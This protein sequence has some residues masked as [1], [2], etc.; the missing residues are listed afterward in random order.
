MCLVVGGG[1]GGCL[2]K[3]QTMFSFLLRLSVMLFFFVPFV[4]LLPVVVERLCS[5]TGRPVVSSFVLLMTASLLASRLRTK[6][7]NGREEA[8]SR[9]KKVR[10]SCLARV[11]LCV[12]LLVRCGEGWFI[13][14]FQS[15]TNGREVNVFFGDHYMYPGKSSSRRGQLRIE[16]LLHCL[17]LCMC[18]IVRVGR[19]SGP[20]LSF[21][22]LSRF[23]FFQS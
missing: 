7:R 14:L 18:E 5:P 3:A 1:G 13:G 15:V 16:R 8:G 20:S 9:S 22:L 4:S 10:S 17:S 6:R 12:V 11:F 21:R 19:I 2:S 23:S